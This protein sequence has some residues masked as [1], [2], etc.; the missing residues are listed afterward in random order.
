LPG[1]KRRNAFF[2]FVNGLL[3]PAAHRQLLQH[4]VVVRSGFWNRLDNVPMLHNLAFFQ[5]ED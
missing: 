2:F 5:P 1:K 3:L 4:R